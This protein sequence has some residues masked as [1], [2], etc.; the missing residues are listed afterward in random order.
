M[1]SKEHCFLRSPEWHALLWQSPVWPFQNLLSR[2]LGLRSRLLAN[3]V[4]LPSLVLYCSRMREEYED[5]AQWNERLPSFI[6]TASAMS[7]NV[8]KWITAEAEPLFFP[9]TSAQ[10]IIRRHMEYPDILS[11]VL[12][13]VANIALLTLGKV[14]R[15]LCDT[16]PQWSTLPEQTKQYQLE[17]SEFFEDVETLEQRRQRATT[18]FEFVQRKSYLHAKPLE[19]ALRSA[20]AS[21]FGGSIDL[22]DRRE[23][24][25]GSDHL[26][27][28]LS[29]YLR[30]A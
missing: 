19:F 1:R 6:H 8:K 16:R 10:P 15:F 2:T 20:H 28:W 27:K 22:L 29:T 9:N 3:L 26:S 13:C 21:G 11:S 23:A 4:E 25:V 14:L 7:D 5:Q 30:T 24:Y 17:C 12:D 18:A